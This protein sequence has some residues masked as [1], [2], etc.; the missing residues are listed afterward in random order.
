M[1]DNLL[2]LEAS[3]LD[4][5]ATTYP[6]EV[7]EDFIWL[8]SYLRD[9]CSRNIDVLCAQLKKIGLTT[10]DTTISRIVRGKLFVEEGKPIMRLTAFR[11]MVDALRSQDRIS[12]MAG[13][14][15]FVE[16]ST[17]HGIR[18]YIDMRRADESV[19]KFGL[20]IGHTGSQKTAC[21][22]QYVLRNNHGTCT[23]IEAPHSASMGDLLTDIGKRYGVSVW[24]SVSAKRNRITEQLNEKK[25][26]II[27]NVQRLY[28]PERGWSQPVF[29]WLQKVQDESG[30]TVILCSIPDFQE[31]L[32]GG[33]DKG[34][35]E[36]FEGRCGGANE[37]HVLPD[38]APKEDVEEIAAA[39][40]LVDYREHT[41]E[42]MEIAR[43]RGRIR[44]L[45]FAL[46]NGKRLAG[47]HPLTIKHVRKAIGAEDE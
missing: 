40:K 6:E 4:Q 12:S 33:I 38:Y 43:R 30:C 29:N 22:T 13:K 2:R 3:W 32:Q 28:R 25:T 47:K 1:A 26:L 15:P 16:T 31:T 5:I 10:S 11:N 17:W 42:L 44:V 7:R 37:F 46:Q 18:D 36:Q 9:K 45:F 39:F 21:L 19:C 34:Y 23:H 41:K 20:I 27:D 24:S 35:F 14:V 8:A